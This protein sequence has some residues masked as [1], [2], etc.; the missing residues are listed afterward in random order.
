MIAAKKVEFGDFQTP[1]ELSS[2]ITAFLRDNGES[3]SVVVEPTCGLGSFITATIEAFP[4]THDFYGFD[5]NLQYVA[6]LGRNLN[7]RNGRHYHIECKNFFQIDWS[8]FL[9]GLSGNLLVIGNP[10]WVTNSALGLLESKNLPEK[11]NFQGRNGFAAKT[12]KANF[13]ISEWMLIKLLE[14]LHPKKACLAMLCKTATA[15]KALRHAWLNNLHVGKCSLHLIDAKKHFNASVE[16]CLLVIHTGVVEKEP[17]AFVYTD[18]SFRDKLSTFGIT[19]RELVADIDEYL[20]L[21]DIDGVPYYKWRSGVKHDAASVM[22]FTKQGKSYINGINEQCDL[23]SKYFFPLLKSSDL[24]NGRLSPERFVL[25]TQKKP[26]DDTL[27]ISTKAPKT[28]EYLVRH[29][30]SLDQRRSIIYEKRP[31]FSI[32]GIGEYTFS[33]W[34]VAISGLYKNSRFQVIGTFQKKPIVFDDTCCFISCQSEDE[35]RFACELLNSDICQQFLRSLVFFDAKRPVTID[36]LN[37]IDLKRVADRLHR[38][39]EARKF[40][41]DAAGFDDKQPLLVFEAKGKY[42]DRRI[43]SKNSRHLLDRLTRPRK[44]VSANLPSAYIIPRKRTKIPA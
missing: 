6:E 8:H 36:V 38:Q 26:S 28:W 1:L 20:R 25:L 2:E 44:T 5:I 32:F 4:N 12:G 40:L 33:P 11:T 30:S 34:K 23:E 31:R 43:I 7:Q 41:S 3:P 37:R 15:R 24:A 16:A 9:S 35:A 14:A 39:K 10:P 22:E 21:R 29:A 18:I 27:V 42:T 19:G 13:D 17:K